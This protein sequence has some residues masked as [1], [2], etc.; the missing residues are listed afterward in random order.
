M[1]RTVLS[2]VCCALLV[3][4]ML[5]T[6]YAAIAPPD[7]GEPHWAYVQLQMVEISKIDG[8]EQAFR[9]DFYMLT[10]W[11]VNNDDIFATT[12]SYFTE[13]TDLTEDLLK[14]STW[15]PRLEFIN[16]RD[17][18]TRLVGEPFAVVAEPSFDVQLV[19]PGYVLPAG[20]IWIVE[21]QRYQCDFTT[22]LK[23]HEFPF[24]SQY[25]ELIIES[26]WDVT[27]LVIRYALPDK[28][29]MLLPDDVKSS[30]V[31]WVWKRSVQVGVVKDYAYN[32]A[33]YDRLYLRTVLERQPEYYLTKVSTVSCTLVASA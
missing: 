12:G 18:T 27:S 1:R 31:G 6:S 25:M 13:D 17:E 16:A 11:V 5:S 8:V 26:F 15:A 2:L 7:I 29:D 4:S 19:R 14:S 21:D 24:D 33:Q 3:L 32:G 22:P 30:I 28:L 9:A 20:H 23:M 10:S